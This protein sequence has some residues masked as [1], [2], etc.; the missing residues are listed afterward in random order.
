VQGLGSHRG[1]G[2]RSLPVLSDETLA[3]LLPGLRMDGQHFILLSENSL[4]P[5]ELAAALLTAVRSTPIDLRTRTPVRLARAGAG[6][7]EVHTDR[8]IIVAGSFVDCT[9]AWGFAP[10]IPAHL[11][12]VP[13]KGQ[14]LAV[15]MPPSLPLHVVIRTP[16]IYI[17]PRTADQKRARLIIGATVEDAGFDKTVSPEDIAKLRSQAAELLPT[18][19]YA[20]ELEAWAG[21]RP[22]TRDQLPLIGQVKKNYFVATGHYRNG[23]LLAPATARVMSQL[24][25]GERVSTNLSAFSPFREAA[26]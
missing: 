16:D 5:R 1:K 8:E 6:S 7:V 18:L 9:G 4:D 23:I 14:M 20:E 11:R 2:A 15:A 12:V 13:R 21:L 26:S 3:L 17:V 19:A 24:L 10:S 25:A 22:A